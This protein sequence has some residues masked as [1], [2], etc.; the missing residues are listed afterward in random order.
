[1][2]T[3]YS[4]ETEL[5]DKKNPKSIE[6]YAQRLIGHVLVCSEQHRKEFTIDSIAMGDDNGTGK[7]VR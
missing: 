4:Y 2:S 7:T 3:K 5:Y 1:M 6:D